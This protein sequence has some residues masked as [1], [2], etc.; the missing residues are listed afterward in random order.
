MSTI[1]ATTIEDRLD[2][3]KTETVANIATF[4][5]RISVLEAAQAA[6]EAQ[7]TT[8]QAQVAALENP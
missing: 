1:K 6:A 3:Q 4:E 7:V 5:A 2:D 8:L